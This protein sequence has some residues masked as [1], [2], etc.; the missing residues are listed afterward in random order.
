MDPRP[1]YGLTADTKQANPEE[2]TQLNPGE[3]KVTTT[4][5]LSYETF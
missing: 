4:V 5:S 2:P 3:N 1:Y